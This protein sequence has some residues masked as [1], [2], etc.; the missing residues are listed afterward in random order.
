[1]AE[2]EYIPFEVY[3]KLYHQSKGFDVGMTSSGTWGRGGAGILV[4]SPDLKEILLLKRSF[5]VLNPGLWGIPGGARKET[6][7]G[8]ENALVTAIAES[9]EE[10]G[11]LPRGRIKKRPYVYQKPGTDFMYVTFILEIDPVDRE[12]FVPQLNWENTCYGWF[13]RDSLNCTQ[14]HPGLKELLKNY[15]FIQF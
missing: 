6:T 4:V 5:H 12:S 10:M 8:L 7:K 3:S 13:R 14:I 11:G 9:S 15:Q 1:M 2:N